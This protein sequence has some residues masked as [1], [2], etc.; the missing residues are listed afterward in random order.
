MRNRLMQAEPGEIPSSAPAAESTSPAEPSTPN[1]YFPDFGEL[2]GESPEV[3]AA[4]DPAPLPVEAP[5]AAGGTPE[6]AP[7]PAATPSDAPAAVVAPVPSPPPV[8]APTEQVAQPAPV[9]TPQAP[10][11]PVTFEKYRDGQMEKL[12]G[13]Y[14]LT[15]AE[16]ESFSSNPKEALPKLAARLH[17]EVFTA[18]HNALQAVL[19][20]TIQSVMTQQRASQENEEAFFKA[21]PALK[22]EKYAQSVLT[23]VRAIRTANPTLDRDNLIKQAGVMAMLANGLNPVS[24]V[25]QTQQVPPQ[26]PAAPMRPAGVGA[27]APVVIPNAP[28][29]GVN[30]DISAMVDA[31]LRGEFY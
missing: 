22:E 20:N 24:T 15:D 29:S 16:A 18:M 7:V 27:S 14:A 19:P 3:S 4:S 31:E 12:T 8:A 6:P 10:Q 17:F 2:V 28:T 1:S 11:E 25:Q 9:P 21:W 13:L 23:A 30:P 5:A 26:P